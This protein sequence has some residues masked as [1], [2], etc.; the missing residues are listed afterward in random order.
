MWI[1][2]RGLNENCSKQKM[3]SFAISLIALLFFNDFRLFNAQEDPS[4]P[5][6]AG[7]EYKHIVKI[8][9]NNKYICDGSLIF[10]DLVLTHANCQVEPL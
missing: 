6:T 10:N 7:N 8:F 2:W 1:E 3:D 5:P 9:Q 4:P